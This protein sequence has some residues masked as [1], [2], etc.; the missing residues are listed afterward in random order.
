MY[1]RKY[2]LSGIRDTTLRVV[3]QVDEYFGRDSMRI[4]NRSVLGDVYARWDS[5]Y[6][7]GLKFQFVPKSDSTALLF[8]DLEDRGG[9]GTLLKF[10][11]AAP[12]FKIYN[13]YEPKPFKSSG[14]KPGNMVPVMLFGSFWYDAE[15][16]KH[17]GGEPAYRFAWRT[18]W[19]RIC[20]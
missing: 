4:L 19:R 5:S 7:S 8:C 6:L 13:S 1:V 16:S 14:L 9:R 12:D 18:K 15:L 11:R 2:D 20:Q 3:F 17:F 10:R